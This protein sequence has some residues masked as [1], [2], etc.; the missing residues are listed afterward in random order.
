MNQDT[1]EIKSMEKW[2]EILGIEKVGQM[3]KDKKLVLFELGEV[4][5]IKDCY[6]E[7]AWFREDFNRITLKG[8]S[9]EEGERRLSKDTS[10]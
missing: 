10:K 6:F 3:V 4:I 9:K 5:K 2:A 1:G 8:I 7:I